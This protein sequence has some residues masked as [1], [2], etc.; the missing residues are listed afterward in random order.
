ML[1]LRQ[2]IRGKKTYTLHSSDDF[3]GIPAPQYC[4]S[5]YPNA[6]VDPENNK[7]SFPHKAREECVELSSD[8]QEISIEEELA[9]A[10]MTLNF[11]TLI[12]VTLK[13]KVGDTKET[14]AKIDD[15]DDDDYPS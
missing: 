2:R 9:K 10:R 15:D 4:Q 1:S 12:N 13:F 5:V 8:G 14:V 3:T 11:D 7:Y 6:S